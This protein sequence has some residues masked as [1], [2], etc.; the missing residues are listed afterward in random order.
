MISWQLQQIRHKIVSVFA[1]YGITIS[2]NLKIV[3]FL[4]VTLNLEN[5]ICKPYRKP[6]DRPR[7]VNSESNHPSQ[8]LKKL[9]KGIEHRLV[10]NSCSEEI[11]LQAIPDYQK[12]LDRCGYI[13]K[14]G[15]N[16]QSQTPVQPSTGRK[17]KSGRVTWFNPPFSFLLFPSCL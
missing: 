8:F 11:F 5:E 15:Y 10:Q 7:Y 1:E 16:Q 13:Y 6:G 12:E 17:R 3:N 14:L 4:D 9:P 2:T